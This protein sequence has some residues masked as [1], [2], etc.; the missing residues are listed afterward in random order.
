MNFFALG[1]FLRV[2]CPFQIFGKIKFLKI[3]TINYDFFGHLK[4]KGKLLHLFGTALIWNWC[5]QRT[6]TTKLIL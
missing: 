2:V 5:L 6:P 4:R 1:T 3:C